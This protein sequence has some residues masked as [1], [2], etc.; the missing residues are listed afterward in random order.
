MASNPRVAVLNVVGLTSR[1]FGEYLPRITAFKDRHGKGCAQVEHVLPAVTSTVQ[2]TYLTGLPP[3]KHGIVGNGWYDRE[4]AE[5][6]FWKQS[7]HLVQGKKIWEVARETKHDFTCARLFWWNNMYSTVDFSITPRPIY[8]ADGSKVFDITSRPLDIR[9]A[10]KK[11]LGA[12]PFFQFWGPASGIASSQWIADSAKWIEEKYRPDLNLVYLPHLDYNLQR[13]GPNSPE[14]FEDLRQI[15][16]VVGDLI[17]FFDKQGVEVV[18]LSEYGITEVDRPIHLNRLFRERGWLQI[19]DD[20]GRDHLELGDCK[21]LAIADHQ[22]AHVYVNDPSVE[23]EVRALLESTEG[24]EAVLDRKAQAEQGI[25]HPRSGDFVVVSDSWSWFT[26]YFWQDDHKAPDYAR[27][28][29]IHRKP[30]YDPVELF[31]DPK[32]PFPKLKIGS[33]LA[34]RKLLGQQPLMDV[35][36]LQADLVKGSHGRRPEH[37]DDLPVIIGPWE[38]L[39]QRKRVRSESVQALLLRAYGIETE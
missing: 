22:V 10:I 21:A 15:D 11:D 9:D 6:L 33:I 24:V 31:L 14:I 5:H 36:P 25:D 19:K 39:G 1:F 32:I 30:G 38:D 16:T 34:R 3:A 4:R 35:I 28:V 37:D 13:V 2:A 12:F 29:D 8:G 27:T 26:Y 7:D 23:S 20:L 18:L 17:D